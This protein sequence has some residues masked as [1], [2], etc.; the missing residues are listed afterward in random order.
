MK[1]DWF[2]LGMMLYEMINGTPP[3]YNRTTDKLLKNWIDIE[4]K[5]PSRW[6]ECPNLVNMIKG[7]LDKN[8]ENRFGDMEVKNHPYFSGID[9]NKVANKELESPRNLDSYVPKRW[10]LTF[11]DESSDEEF[12]DRIFD[13][14]EKVYK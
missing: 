7:L 9:W 10:S 8:P 3:W 6:S 14:W 5:I 11:K 12:N 4:L 13:G 1:A 2:V